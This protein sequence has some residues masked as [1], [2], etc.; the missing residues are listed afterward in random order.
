MKVDFVRPVPDREIA[1]IRTRP[2]EFHFLDFVRVLRSIVRRLTRYDSVY[3]ERWRMA[4]QDAVF[5]VQCT[6][7]S[8]NRCHVPKR[9]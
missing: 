1:S 9:R 7:H 4:V 5:G 2:P 3:R 8:A 6:M